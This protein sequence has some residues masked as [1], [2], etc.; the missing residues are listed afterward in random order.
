MIKPKFTKWDGGYRNNNDK[1]SSY[2]KN[3]FNEP[4]RT[5]LNG[6]DPHMGSTES[7]RDERDRDGGDAVFIFSVMGYGGF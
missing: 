2:I 1:A 3:T 5:K 7:P 4:Q 6:V